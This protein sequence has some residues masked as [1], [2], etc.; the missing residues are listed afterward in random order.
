MIQYTVDAGPNTHIVRR[1]AKRSVIAKQEGETFTKKNI[2]V[3]FNRNN[4]Q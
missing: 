1:P 3:S 2:N 4:K